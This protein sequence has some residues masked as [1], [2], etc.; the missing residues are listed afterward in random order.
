MD[1]WIVQL[2]QGMNA[3]TRSYV[4]VGEEYSEEFEVTVRVHQGFLLSL[5]LFIIVLGALS[6]E[7]RSVV[8]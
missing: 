7:F 6:G 5:L 3:N 8:P 2:A 1:G 4:H